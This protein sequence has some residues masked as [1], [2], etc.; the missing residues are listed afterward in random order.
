MILERTMRSRA[1][2]LAAMLVVLAL[3]APSALA[4][5]NTAKAKQLYDEGV[6]NYNLGHFDEALAAFD[7]AYRIRHDAV[8]LYNIAQCQRQLR[9]YEDAERSYRAYLRESPDLSQ[10][11]RDQ[12]QKLIADMER[13]AAEERAKPTPTTSAPTDT[14]LSGQP[15][16]TSVPTQPTTTTT[17]AVEASPPQRT[18]PVYKRGWFWG[19]IAGAAVVVGVGVGV[20]VGLGTAKSNP[21]P[22]VQF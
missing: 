12:V 16:P 15:K 10:S 5:A 9:K 2:Q 21:F 20:G 14:S 3:T 1:W 17:L 11:T 22:P 6:T 13:S 8:F 4:D 7:S 18:K 19:V